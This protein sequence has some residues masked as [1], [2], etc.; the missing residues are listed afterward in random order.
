MKLFRLFTFSLVLVA[1]SGCSLFSAASPTPTFP[2]TLQPTETQQSL[3]ITLPTE[4][5]PT[6]TPTVTQAALPTPI[7][8]MPATSGVKGL[9]LRSGPGKLFEI[10]ATYDENSPLTVYGKAPGEQWYFT[11]TQDHRAGWMFKEFV[12]L[13]GD[14]ADLPYIS[15]ADANVISG[16]VKTSDGVPASGIGISLAD[17]NQDISAGPDATVTDAT[18]TFYLYIPKNTTGNFAIGA[19]AYNCESNLIEGKCNLPY[20]L[21]SSVHSFSLPDDL[22]ISFEFVLEHN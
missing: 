5:L 7:T 4:T 20:V 17:A 10:L 22:G 18:G 19:N 13:Q 11:V 14:A 6:I 2:P 9:V 16:H 8:P 3:L 12:M 1:L 15:P 21:P